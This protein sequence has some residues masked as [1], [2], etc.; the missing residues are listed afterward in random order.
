MS[1]TQYNMQYNINIFM[2]TVIIFKI[3]N[4]WS[5]MYKIDFNVSY[6]E[7]ISHMPNASSVAVWMR[8]Y[9][10][11]WIERGYKTQFIEW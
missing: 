7:K 6:L 2:N 8:Y 1:F 10:H 9:D 3:S 11:L 4:R 5:V